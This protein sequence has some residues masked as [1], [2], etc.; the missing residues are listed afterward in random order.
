MEMNSYYIENSMRRTDEALLR[1]LN[2]VIP[3]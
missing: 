2:M 3:Q 1:R